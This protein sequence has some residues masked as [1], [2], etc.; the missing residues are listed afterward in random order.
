MK[1]QCTGPLNHLSLPTTDPTATARFFQKYFGCEVVATGDHVLLNRDGF[2]IVLERVPHP[3]QWPSSFHVGFELATVEQVHGLHRTFEADGVT[4]ETG[5]F[6][7]SRGSRF[8]CRTPEGILLEVNTR[9]DKEGDW[10]SLF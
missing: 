9:Q 1:M 7:N 5:V 3:V 6:N 10:R 2:D 4:M 8:F